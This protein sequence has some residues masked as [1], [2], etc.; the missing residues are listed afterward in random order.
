MDH[1]ER[2]LQAT[3]DAAADPANARQHVNRISS[4][5]KQHKADLAT[6]GVKKI[7]TVPGIIPVAAPAPG[8]QSLSQSY[9]VEWPGGKGKV[10]SLFAGT[11]DGALTSLSKIGMRIQINGEAELITTGSSEGYA[12]LAA[13]QPGN[14]NWFR[15]KDFPVDPGQKWYVYFQNFE[16]SGSPYTPFLMFGWAEA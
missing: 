8:A 11:V 6:L 10:K 4:A 16:T 7:I 14:F 1:I 15:L 9:K 2:A 3:E 12:Q 13:F 5:L